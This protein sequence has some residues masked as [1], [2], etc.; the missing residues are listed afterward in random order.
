MIA[1]AVAKN[2]GYIDLSLAATQRGHDYAELHG[3]PGVLSFAHWYL[4][5]GRTRIGA[6]NRAA[7]MLTQGIDDFSPNCPTHRI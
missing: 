2:F 3:D 5:L 7:A 6:R 1:A 4:T